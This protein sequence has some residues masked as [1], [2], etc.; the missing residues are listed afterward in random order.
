[1]PS[2]VLRAIRAQPWA[3]TPDYL[4]VIERIAERA[5]DA[6]EVIAKAEDGH[7][8]RY[9][10]AVAAMG[11]R[12]D[13]ARRTTIRNGVACIPILGPIFPRS[14]VMSD[15]SGAT[16]LD[17]AAADLRV[18]QLSDAVTR[19]L[20][21]MDS[22]GGAVSGT[23]EFAGLIAAS[24]KPVTAHVTG[25]GASACYWIASQAH[26]IVLDR[27]GLVGSIGVVMSVRAQEHADRD[28]Y[29]QYDVVSSNAANKR[30]D[31]NTEAGR[32]QLRAELD[33]IEKVF[34][35]DVAKGRGVTP[36][37]VIENFGR[38]GVKVG[39]SALDA[40]MVDR[41]GTLEDT[42]TRLARGGGAT[43][44]AGDR[45]ADLETEVEAEAEAAPD[46][47][48]IPDTAAIPDALPRTGASTR[49]A[50]L[51]LDLRRR[52]ARS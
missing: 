50:S 17:V 15:Y 36:K 2:A 7:E 32:E 4:A 12:L 39:K 10:Q 51:Q 31:F 41:L 30:P 21:V 19:I 33:Q 16:S 45:A 48:A 6:P 35:G 3:I 8:A 9:L 38:G 47:T 13:G 11:S 5:L 43:G 44:K 42:L 29:R 49:L 1:M 28:G 25:L 22:P 26:E 24:P 46:T 34:I 23:A 37:T 20:L 14:N 40:G 52:R 18:A 27:A